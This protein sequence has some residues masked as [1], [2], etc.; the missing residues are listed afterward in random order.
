[1]KRDLPLKLYNQLMMIRKHKLK[2]MLVNFTSMMHN[3][4]N[5]KQTK[6]AWQNSRVL[7]FRP[8]ARFN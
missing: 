8:K 7:N 1:M 6:R 2:N 5:H 3:L 4:R